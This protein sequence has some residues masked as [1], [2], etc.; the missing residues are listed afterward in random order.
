MTPSSG[1]YTSLAAPTDT[2]SNGGSSRDVTLGVGI[3]VGVGMGLL[4]VGALVFYGLQRRRRNMAPEAP[5]MDVATNSAWH[6]GSDTYES[7]PMAASTSLA[8]L[9]AK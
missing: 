1:T 6:Q 3:G 5:V 9:S 2:S 7:R 8:E 4:V